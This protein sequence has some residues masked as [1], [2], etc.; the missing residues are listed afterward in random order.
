VTSPGSPPI[1]LS[2]PGLIGPNSILNPPWSGPRSGRGTRNRPFSHAHLEVDLRAESAQ[3]GGHPLWERFGAFLA[4]R[5]IV[6]SAD[7]VWLTAR[8]LHA[9]ASRQFRRVDHWEV[10][11]GGWLPP[12]EFASVRPENAEPVGQLLS[13]LESGDGSTIARARSFSVRVSDLHGDRADITVRRVHRARRHALSVDLWGTW[14]KETINELVGAL[15]ERLPVTQT[16]MTKYQYAL[17]ASRR[18]SR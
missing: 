15:A 16:T 8:T 7:L 12:P 14:T 4:E 2:A 1:P 3:A 17:Q 6:E 9:L 5:K 11:P 10:A 18:G 13:A